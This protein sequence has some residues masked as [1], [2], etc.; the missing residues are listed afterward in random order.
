MNILLFSDRAE[1]SFPSRPARVDFPFQRR[2]RRKRSH[3]HL[4]PLGRHQG[5]N[6]PRLFRLARKEIWPARDHPLARS[7]RR[8]LANRPL[9][10]RRISGQSQRRHRRPLRRR[11]RSLSR[12]REGRPA[13]P[14]D[15]PADILAQIPAQLNGMDIYR[16]RPR[17]VRRG[18]V[19]LRHHHQRTRARRPS[20]CPKSTPGPT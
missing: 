11:G 8:H 1:G 10:P 19:G 13:H 18:L 16:S 20:A 2:R 14:Y 4:A 6:L 7:G 17:M 5:G 15:P 3:R 12:S 9:S